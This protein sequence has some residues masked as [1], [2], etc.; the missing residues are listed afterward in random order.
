MGFTATN[1]MHVWS[2]GGGKT[3][4]HWGMIGGVGISASHYC[5]LVLRLTESDLG[6][7]HQGVLRGIRL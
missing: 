1:L 3:R 5:V 6:Y 4:G 7:E 2:S